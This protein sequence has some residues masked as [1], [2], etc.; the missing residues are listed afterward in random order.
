MAGE[1]KGSC[2]STAGKAIEEEDEEEDIA[3]CWR[4]DG[5]GLESSVRKEKH[6]KLQGAS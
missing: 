4:E 3:K 5:E 2:A 1:G 6:H